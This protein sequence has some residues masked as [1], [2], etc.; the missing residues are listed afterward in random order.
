[1][2]FET[3]NRHD[4][5]V[6]T[7][8][9][10]LVSHP[11][12]HDQFPQFKKPNLR[13]FFFF[14]KISQKTCAPSLNPF[15][16]VLSPCLI[17][18]TPTHPVSN[19]STTPLFHLCAAAQ[20]CFHSLPPSKQCPRFRPFPLVVRWPCKKTKGIISVLIIHVWWEA[21]ATQHCKPRK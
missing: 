19:L 12:S 1:M 4:G 18:P 11:H 7:E 13:P 3:R 16:L 17:T 8:T 6:L 10:S 5:N 20:A 15:H 14:L 21:S 9:Q 2:F